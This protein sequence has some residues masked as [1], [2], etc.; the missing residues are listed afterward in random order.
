MR[1]PLAK[2]NSRR[3]SRYTH[4]YSKWHL[5]PNPR[6]RLSRG[7]NGEGA[8][9]S[10]VRTAT[11]TVHSRRTYDLRVFPTLANTVIRQHRAT[12]PDF[13]SLSLP[14]SSYPSIELQSN[15]EARSQLVW[16]CNYNRGHERKTIVALS[17]NNSSDE[18]TDIRFDSTITRMVPCAHDTLVFPRHQTS[19]VM[20]KRS[21]SDFAA[22]P[23]KRI[24]TRNIRPVAVS[25]AAATENIE[26]GREPILGELMAAGGT[27]EEIK[28]QI[29]GLTNELHPL[30][31][32]QNICVCKNADRQ[33]CFLPK[34]IAE[35]ESAAGAI[36]GAL[37]PHWEHG[38]GEFMLYSAMQLATRL[39]THEDTLP[40]WA[41]VIDCSRPGEGGERREFNV[42]ARKRLDAA[43]EVVQ[44]SR[45][46]RWND[47]W[48]R[49]RPV[50]RLLGGSL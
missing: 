23:S 17:S 40:F 41:G 19:S 36:E 1:Y 47:H 44:Q 5:P 46:T 6:H 33:Y 37:E 4:Q 32:E 3:V 31:D 21:F 12:L 26:N 35:L 43:K 42:R 49:L 38:L 2:S 20:C 39:I 11:H 34:K 9:R 16:K 27:L 22:R 45:S 8:A 48:T 30:F 14:A 15:K 28:S 24:T 50:F 25:K 29:C 10:T 7:F 18:H 13:L